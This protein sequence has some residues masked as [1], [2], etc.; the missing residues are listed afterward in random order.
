MA[1]RHAAALFLRQLKAAALG[2]N[3]DKWYMRFIYQLVKPR[4][5]S[6]QDLSAVIPIYQKMLLGNTK[7]LKHIA[8]FFSTSYRGRLM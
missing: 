5:I 8:R 1:Y 4:A 7:L 3:S 6:L 2:N